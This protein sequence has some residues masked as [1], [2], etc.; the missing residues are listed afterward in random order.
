[1]PHY[2][3]FAQDD[4]LGA[5]RINS[6]MM[7][8]EEME[9]ELSTALSVPN[10]V[11]TYFDLKGRQLRI[12]AAHKFDTHYEL[13]LNHP[14]FVDT[15]TSVLFKGGT[16]EAMLFKIQPGKEPN[17]PQRLIVVPDGR[18][19]VLIPGESLILRDES[20][21]VLDDFFPDYEIER[22]KLVASRGWTKYVLSY[23]ESQRDIDMFR[24]YVGNDVEVVAK[25]ESRK[26]LEWVARG[27]FKPKDNLRLMTAR[28]D[29]YLELTK[30]HE[31]LDAQRLIIEKDPRAVVGSRILLTC[32]KGPVPEANDFSELAW[33]YDIGYRTMMLCDDLCIDETL[34]ARAI[35]V[36]DAFRTDY[37]DKRQALVSATPKITA[38][39]PSG[40]SLVSMLRA[41]VGKV[42]S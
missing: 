21:K 12:R 26:G 9:G 40:S 27:G 5:I 41:I 31:M 23:V 35:N 17:S 20:F 42:G 30:P 10:S 34:L 19:D 6:A 2:K 7:F 15:P 8:A 29:L 36:F 18:L 25:I 33:L 4:R 14:I 3:R 16:Q 38:A 13:E 32:C 11:P 37:A 24:E 1:M 28:G 22:I 39:P